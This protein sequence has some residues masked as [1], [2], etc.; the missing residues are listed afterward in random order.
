MGEAAWQSS[1]VSLA[2]A[3]WERGHGGELVLQP[4][5]GLAVTVPPLMDRLVIFRSDRVLHR[6]LPASAPRY[7]FTVWLDGAE[8][9]INGD[10][11]VNLKA[12]GAAV[13]RLLCR[14]VARCASVT[15]FGRRSFVS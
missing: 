3:G 11:D 10:D 6:V 7:C 4:F 5:L 12:S 14:R 13:H 8:G 2:R 15:A 1:D 9:T